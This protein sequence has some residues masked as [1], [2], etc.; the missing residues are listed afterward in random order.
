LNPSPSWDCH[1]KSQQDS[2]FDHQSSE[3]HAWHNMARRS[4]KG[5][6][7]VSVVCKYRGP[8]CVF[9]IILCLFIVTT[10][11]STCRKT[12]KPGKSNSTLWTGQSPLLKFNVIP[13]VHQKKSH[14][15]NKMYQHFSVM[16]IHAICEKLHDFRKKGTMWVKIKKI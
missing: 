7:V 14:S 1:L 13:C 9:I 6:E 4:L 10:L 5:T 12:V 8:D 16:N 11:P 15:F 3:M 2:L